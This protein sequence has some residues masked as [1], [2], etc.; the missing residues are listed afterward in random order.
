MFEGWIEN[1]LVGWDFG[2]KG[3][4]LSGGWGGKLGVAPGRD[5][6]HQ[7]RGGKLLIWSP[8]QNHPLPP[9]IGLSRAGG[10][11]RWA[12]S[13]SSPPPLPPPVTIIRNLTGVG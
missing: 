7:R 3:C 9:F 2:T 6:P 13:G 1:G 4:K 11:G 12:R 5:P 8:N 10:G